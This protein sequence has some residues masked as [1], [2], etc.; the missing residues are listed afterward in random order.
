MYYWVP[1]GAEPGWL[2]D[3]FMF[4]R[5]GRTGVQRYEYQYDKENRIARIRFPDREI[6]SGFRRWQGEKG[7][8]PVYKHM[9]WPQDT[10]TFDEYFAGSM[11]TPDSYMQEVAP[12]VLLSAQCA[13]NIKLHSRKFLCGSKYKVI[14]DSGGSQLKHGTEAHV[15]PVKVINMINNVADIGCVLDAPPRPQD[16]NSSKVM[17]ALMRVQKQNNGVFF[18]HWNGEVKLLNAVHGFTLKQAREWAK[19]TD[20]DRFYGWAAGQD[21]VQSFL[22]GLRTTLVVMKEFPK[23]HYHTFGLG[24]AAVRIPIA[25]WLGKYVPIFTSDST[26]H[27]ASVR[28]RVYF[29]NTPLGDIEKVRLGKSKREKTKSKTGVVQSDGGPKRIFQDMRPLPCSCPVCVRVKYPVFFSF[30]AG[31]GSGTL[32]NVH[33]TWI[34]AQHASSWSELAARSS[35]GEYLEAIALSKE[36]TA[37]SSDIKIVIKYIEYVMKHGLDEADR[38]YKAAIGGD[39]AIVAGRMKVLFPKRQSRCTDGNLKQAMLGSAQSVSEDVLPAYLG[40]EEMNRLGIRRLSD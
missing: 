30:D 6:I 24:G 35:V 12:Y 10:S 29:Y 21:N 17:L 22:A 34:T 3:A 38:K 39:E 13:D 25:A 28:W 4:I 27:M 7:D 18:D 33:N 9:W 14:V 23:Q 36:S 2:F 32:L 1:A 31:A 40:A 8:R 11:Y 19:S 15:D 5:Y 20:D 37:I 26:T 16:Q